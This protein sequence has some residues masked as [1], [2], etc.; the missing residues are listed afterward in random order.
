[1]ARIVLTGT[2]SAD[3]AAILNDLHA[4]AGLPVAIKFRSLF[5]E[6]YDRLADHPASGPR[7]PALGPAIRIGIVAPYVVLYEPSASDDTVTILRIVH[8]RREI[9]RS[10]LSGTG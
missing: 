10:L 9:S 6:L 2:A 8:G 7:R 3:Q 5:G 1:M 4:K